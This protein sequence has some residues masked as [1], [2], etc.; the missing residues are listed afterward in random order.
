MD[1]VW[2]AGVI[3]WRAT[4][5]AYA[6]WGTFQHP[7][8]QP[9]GATEPKP[10]A[11]L[12]ETERAAYHAVCEPLSGLPPRI[13]QERIPLYVAHRALLAAAHLTRVLGTG[14]TP[15]DRRGP[16]V[17]S[18]RPA[19]CSDPLD[20]TQWVPYGRATEIWLRR[21]KRISTG[22]STERAKTGRHGVTLIDVW[23]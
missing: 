12:T 14:A 18:D 3:S 4:Y 7:N 5:H 10:L 9:I 11:N 17:A 21:V 8:G 19:D 23:T 1:F 15:T 6:P 16:V 20:L 22:I 13:E 2:L